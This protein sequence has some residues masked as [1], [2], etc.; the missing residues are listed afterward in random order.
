MWGPPMWVGKKTLHCCMYGNDFRPYIMGFVEKNTKLH[1]YLLYI[2]PTAY[3]LCLF[4]H[5]RVWWVISYKTNI[6][7]LISVCFTWVSDATSLRL[8]EGRR[9]TKQWHKIT[10]YIKIYLRPCSFS[11]QCNQCLAAQCRNLKH[12]RSCKNVWIFKTH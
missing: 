11:I 2:G 9:K 8:T 3:S 5:H 10:I 12:E 6:P 4:W 1:Q 7:Q